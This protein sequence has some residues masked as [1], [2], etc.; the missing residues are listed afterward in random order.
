MNNLPKDPKS[1]NPKKKKVVSEKRDPVT[2]YGISSRSSR[3]NRSEADKKSVR[4]LK[5]EDALNTNTPNQFKMQRAA[6]TKGI[7]K[8]GKY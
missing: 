5:T 3:P 2:G 6:D 1:P 8:I 7:T 4:R